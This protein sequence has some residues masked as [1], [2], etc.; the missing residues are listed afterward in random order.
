M[1]QQMTAAAAGVLLSDRLAP[2]L[3][4][5]GPRVA[6][7]GGGFSGLAAAYELSHAG[8]D[9]TVLEGRNRIGG[10]VLSFHDLVPGGTVE[11][12]GELIGSN[13]PIWN[14]YKER[15]KLAFRDIT[16]D[17]VEAPVVLGGRRLT[18]AESRQLW[19][20]MGAALSLL[21]ADAARIEDPFAPWLSPGAQAF[22][23]RPLRSFIDALDTSPTTASA[24][25][26]RVTSPTSRW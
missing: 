13:H 19:T 25:P 22:D 26:G 15:F 2:A 17:D 23:R 3:R 14:R 24:P 10:R 1:L 11:G 4:A 6:I 16:A 12:G 20:D 18:A 8:A 9:V 5:A 21:D 7:V